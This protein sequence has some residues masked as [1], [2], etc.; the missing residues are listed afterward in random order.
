MNPC[1]E[2]KG[3]VE[4][5]KMSKKLCYYHELMQ[6]MLKQLKGADTTKQKQ[7]EIM[8]T[9]L[10]GRD[11]KDFNQEVENRTK[12]STKPV[13]QDIIKPD[14]VQP[15]QQ[16]IVKPVKQDNVKPRV[17]AVTKRK[18]QV[19]PVTANIETEKTETNIH[20]VIT[21]ET[22]T[23]GSKFYR[24]ESMT[25][26][27]VMKQKLELAVTQFTKRVENNL[28]DEFKSFNITTT[29]NFQS[30][31]FRFDDHSKNFE[32]PWN[33]CLKEY[34]E[35]WNELHK[36]LFVG[37]DFVNPCAKFFMV[38][39]TFSERWAYLQRIL[40]VLKQIKD[41]ITNNVLKAIMF[42][43]RVHRGADQFF[44]AGF[45]QEKKKDTRIVQQ[46]CWLSHNQSQFGKVTTL[47]E[48]KYST[49]KYEENTLLPLDIWQNPIN[50]FKTLV[51]YVPNCSFAKY[52]A[53]KAFKLFDD[54]Y[55]Q[56]Y[57]S[58]ENALLSSYLT[59]QI[60]VEQKQQIDNLNYQQIMLESHKFISNPY[61]QMCCISKHAPKN[62]LLLH[63]KFN[64]FDYEI[65]LDK[66]VTFSH[67]PHIL[68]IAQQRMIPYLIQKK[69]KSR[70][71]DYFSIAGT[72]IPTQLLKEN[73]FFDIQMYQ[74]ERNEAE[75]NHYR[76]HTLEIA[77]LKK[78]INTLQARL[79]LQLK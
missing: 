45:E 29:E 33:E 71:N 21:E 19:K 65:C 48:I 66:K 49:Q 35:K 78:T 53:E 23:D 25:R 2:D 54:F 77:K 10:R 1:C 62:F 44:R 74:Q 40:P 51:A 73:E 38:H 36:A 61:D 12:R 13:Q 8:I 52:D 55:V 63:V 72:K 68:V 43:Y 9:N 70:T 31:A 7:L 6:R 60:T 14:I 28:R 15:V 26:T 57:Q 27:V 69:L 34:Q 3:C 37:E 41:K 58:L 17:Y 76:K 24:E 42:I 47:Q 46:D 59:Y 16:D 22:K 18:S 4:L 20:K 64:N 67:F 32:K 30:K 11:A 75:S 5:V 79:P 56:N 50:L 39:T